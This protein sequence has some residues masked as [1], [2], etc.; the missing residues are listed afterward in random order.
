VG[1]GEEGIDF[2]VRSVEASFDAALARDEEEAASDLA[3][4]L[5]QERSLSEVVER[6]LG[7]V[8]VDRD[9]VRSRVS[10]VGD[11]FVVE[12]PPSARLVPL[13]TAVFESSSGGVPPHR[14][15][16]DLTAELRRWAR[17]AARVS[18]LTSVGVVAGQ[19]MRAAPDHLTIRGRRGDHHVG[20][21]ALL[22]IKRTGGGTADGS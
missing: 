17:S 15:H 1:L 2:V 21:E 5:L 14:R 7:L 9:G 19:L 18:A 11:D 20:R 16:L 10:E 3:F 4:S 12:A 13:S 6:S 22:A 8:V